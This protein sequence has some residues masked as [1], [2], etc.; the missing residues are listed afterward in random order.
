MRERGADPYTLQK[1]IKLLDVDVDDFEDELNLQLLRK[2]ALMLIRDTLLIERQVNELDDKIALLIKNRISL[3]EVFGFS[4]KQ[5]RY[6]LAHEQQAKLEN[7][8]GIITLK[9]TD[10]DTQ[11]KRKKYQELFY[12]LQTQPKYLANLMFNMNKTGGASVT[13][14]LEG[15]VLTLFG[16]VQSNRE[17]YLF[18]NLIDTCISLEVNGIQKIEDFWRDNP[19]FIKLVLQYIRGA[20]ERKFLRM[21]LQ[22]LIKVV[23]DDQALELEI[24]PVAVY[25]AIIRMDE[26][27]SGEKSTRNYDA[28]QA[29]A[30][31]DEDVILI[32]MGRIKKLTDISERFL[33]AITKSTL[34]YG[35]RYI[36]MAMKDCFVKK[37]PSP[38]QGPEIS[39]IVGNLLYYRYMNPAI[40]APEAFDI[41]DTAVSPSQ[42][43]NLAEISKTLHQIQVSRILTG[44]GEVATNVNAFINE[45]SKHFSLFIKNSCTVETIQD[46]FG[47][48]ELLDMSSHGKPFIYITPEEIIQV[49]HDLVENL[50]NLTSDVNDPLQIILNELGPAPA[51][52]SAAKGHGSELTLHLTNRFAKTENPEEVEKRELISATKVLVKCVLRIQS[53]KTLLKILEEPVNVG[54]QNNFEDYLHMSSNASL[55]KKEKVGSALNSIVNIHDRETKLASNEKLKASSNE[56]LKAPSNENLKAPSNEKLKAPSNEKLNAI[57]NG[58]L[59]ASTG[60][61]V[62]DPSY[63]QHLRKED[64]SLYL[65]NNYLV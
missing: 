7:E 36:A 62:K 39:R 44:T 64:G 63:L 47:M 26:V 6:H 57:S 45:S 1:Y 38:E 12:L 8:T 49:H 40:I 34:P 21:L 33:T 13:K 58:E 5:M 11:E 30:A 50:G 9:G 32:Q 61:L 42:R 10:K 53:G 23:M 16:H 43:K 14:F 59:N 15:V 2:K 52:G 65:V 37:F 17:E 31:A 24:E 56:Q 51:V 4:S 54:L 20:K 19:L 25:K 28:T 46:Y 29:D 35:I 41:I 55:K 48:D 60:A 22:P 27:S 18:L 3:E